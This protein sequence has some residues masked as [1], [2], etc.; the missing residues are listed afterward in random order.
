MK[1]AT[2]DDLARRLHGICDAQPFATAWFAKDLTTGREADR[3]GRRP[4]PSASTRKTSIMMA[5]LAAA[6]AGRLRLDEPVE[7]EARLQRDVASGTYRYMTP[8]CAIPLRDAVVNMMVTS[9]NVCTQIVL[10][11]LGGDPE[12]LNAYCR[13]IGIEATVHRDPIPPAGLAWDHPVEA[14]AST[15]AADQ[16]L[17]L[18]LILRGTTDGAAAA[19]L[20]CTPGLCRFGLDILGWQLLRTMIPSLLPYGTRVAHKTGRGARGRMDAG[21]VFR[22]DR[23]LYI[24]AAFTDRV[25]EEMPDGLPGYAAAFA[26]IGRLSRACWDGIRG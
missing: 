4:L 13:A 14:N 17:L 3:D 19:R 21:I 1:E 16:A 6:H 2:M 20:G 24:L 12:A 7:I 15:T 11:R 22:G 5:A 26:T 8:G 18:D 25:P 9:D 23:P 10:E